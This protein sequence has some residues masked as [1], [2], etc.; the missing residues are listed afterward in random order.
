MKQRTAL[1]W[2]IVLACIMV[3]IFTI[4]FIN[5]PSQWWYWAPP[6][7]AFLLE[8]VFAIMLLCNMKAEKKKREAWEA[9]NRK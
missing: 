9:S 8:V 2:Y 1:I 5:A 3:P 6:F 4:N 7:A